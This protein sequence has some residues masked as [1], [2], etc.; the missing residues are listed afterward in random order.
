MNKLRIL[1]PPVAGDPLR[2]IL[3][4]YAVGAMLGLLVVAGFAFITVAFLR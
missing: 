1:S 2:G 3:G 4:Y